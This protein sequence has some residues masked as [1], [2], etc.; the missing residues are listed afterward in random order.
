[1]T[2]WMTT[3]VMH[4]LM[5]LGSAYAPLE[6]GGVLLGWRDG[7]NRIVVDLIGAGPRALHGQHTFLPDHPWQMSQ[8]REAF[9]RSGGD[10]DYL[11]DWHTHPGGVAEMSAPDRSTLRRIGRRVPCAIMVIAAGGQNSGWDLRCWMHQRA[12]WLKA[13]NAAEQSVRRFEKPPGWPGACLQ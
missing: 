6:T 9:E 13:S 1:M 3:P 10:L 2:V 4:R 12:G 7:D 8:I 5:E 11:G